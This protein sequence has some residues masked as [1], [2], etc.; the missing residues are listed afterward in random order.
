M[1]WAVVTG[2][3]F[4]NCCFAGF[5][6]RVAELGKSN[7]VLLARQNSIDNRHTCGACQVADYVMELDVHLVQRLLHVLNMYCRHLNQTFPVPPHR[8]NSAD[9]LWRTMRSTQKPY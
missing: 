9:R 1:L 7:R 2:H 4:S 8:S 6:F 5:D 3:G